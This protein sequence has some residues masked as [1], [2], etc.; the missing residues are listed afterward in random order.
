MT[1]TPKK[2]N[3]KSHKKTKTRR[4]GSMKQYMMLFESNPQPMWIYDLETLSFLDVNDAA[5][6]HYGYSRDEFL[7]MT[8]K[9]IRPNEDVPALLDNVSR[10]TSGLDAAGVWRHRK[11]DGSIIF[12]EITS[13]TLNFKGRRAEVILANDITER[14]R[15]EER[16][17]K[18]TECFLCFGSDPIENINRLTALCGELM[19][20]VEYASRL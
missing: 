10:V 7:S 9:D 3:N 13:H 4:Q 20:A 5:I 8:I 18:L 1:E 15:T 12:V 16:M 6:Y 14:R 11:K 17:A 19:G 2:S